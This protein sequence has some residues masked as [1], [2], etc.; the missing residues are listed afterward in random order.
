[1][2]KPEFESC[3]CEIVDRL[4]LSGMTEISALHL[5]AE[6]IDAVRNDEYI[7]G[8]PKQTEFQA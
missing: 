8:L 6:F 7:G 5:V 2:A 3:L 1:M 4:I